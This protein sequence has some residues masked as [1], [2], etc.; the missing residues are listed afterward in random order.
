M[1][2]DVS[3]LHRSNLNAL[4]LVLDV[5]ESKNFSMATFHSSAKAFWHAV[6]DPDLDYDCGTVACAVG[7]GP[8]AGIEAEPGENWLDYAA[9]A[10]G[11]DHTARAF[12]F[13]FSGTLTYVDNT[14]SG[15]AARIR[16]YLEEGIPPE[17]VSLFGEYLRWQITGTMGPGR[18]AWARARMR[19]TYA[20]Y[21]RV[22]TSAPERVDRL[23]PV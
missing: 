16:C 18:V 12:D 13:L 19:Q 11:V 4:A 3:N 22:P 20:R 2:P 6:A 7:H 23:L 9:R 15:A 14:P 8:R 10:F 5:V 21:L 1:N 17:F